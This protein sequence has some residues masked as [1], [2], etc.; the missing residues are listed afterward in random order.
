MGMRM[1]YDLWQARDRAKTIHAPK[2]L[3]ATLVLAAALLL[4]AES[5]LLRLGTDRGDR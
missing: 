3:L 5:S 1:A 4:V 2:G